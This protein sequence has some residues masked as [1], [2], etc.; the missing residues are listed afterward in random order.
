MR[1]RCNPQLS[2]LAFVDLAAR[3]APDQPQ[4]TVK[5]LADRALTELSPSSTGW[6]PRGAPWRCNCSKG[7]HAKPTAAAT[8]GITRTAAF[9]D[10]PALPGQ[11][12][13][14]AATSTARAAPTG[15]TSSAAI[16]G[17]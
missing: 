8:K 3:I 10:H 9:P 7:R 13:G 4:R 11:R 1:G 16:A 5:R 14:G 12:A 15:S 2:M 6:A 17:S